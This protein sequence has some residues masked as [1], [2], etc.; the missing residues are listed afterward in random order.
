[1]KRELAL[2]LL[3]TILLRLLVA[4]APGSIRLVLSDIVGSGANLAAFLRLPAALRGDKVGSRPED[5]ERQLTALAAHAESVI[6]TRLLNLYASVE[7]YALPEGTG[8]LARSHL[9]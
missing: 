5:L 2:Q 8:R 1:M 6:Q 4:S 3:Q 7:E 9:V